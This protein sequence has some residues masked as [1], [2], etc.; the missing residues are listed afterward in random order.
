MWTELF[1]VDGIRM[2]SIQQDAD[3]D[4]ITQHGGQ[5]LQLTGRPGGRMFRGEDFTANQPISAQLPVVGHHYTSSSSS[6]SSCVG[7]K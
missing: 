2:K 3:E 5:V 1:G 6:S 7:S 4:P